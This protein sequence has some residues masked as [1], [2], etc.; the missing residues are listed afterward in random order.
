VIDSSYRGMDLVEPLASNFQLFLRR[1]ETKQVGL[2][3]FIAA[4]GL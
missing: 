3:E 1:S 4:L 2:A